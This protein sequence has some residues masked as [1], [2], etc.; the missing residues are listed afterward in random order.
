MPNNITS[1]RAGT[2]PAQRG[3]ALIVAMVFLIIMTILGLSS[4]NT[5][6]MELRIANNTQFADLA[7]QAAE[8][9][10]DL[11][12]STDSL[13]SKLNTDETD[14]VGLKL[15]YPKLGPKKT[16]AASASASARYV[17]AGHA[18]GYSISTPALHYQI[19][20]TGKAAAGG[21]S[22]NVQGFFII[23]AKAG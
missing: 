12:L 3:S 16:P 10:I 19:T 7:F 20:S 2:K 23:G 11:L 14:L 6:R 9:G 1:I 17:T 5:S 18:P 15:D 4:M 22:Q 13:K 21:E 8:S